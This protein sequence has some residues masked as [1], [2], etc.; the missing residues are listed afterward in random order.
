VSNPPLLTVARVRHQI[1]PSARQ[2]AGVVAGL[3]RPADVRANGI[4]LAGRR[5]TDLADQG[6]A[7]IAF[8][9]H[10]REPRVDE[11]RGNPLELGLALQS[12]ARPL[13]GERATGA[14]APAK[15]FVVDRAHAFPA[16]IPGAP[17]ANAER[18]PAPFPR[19]PR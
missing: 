11:R 12:E 16:R 18:P 5:H 3:A 1:E 8:T 17:A 2:M 14:A 15:R 19:K 6:G 7:T 13:L 4:D 9:L 10:V